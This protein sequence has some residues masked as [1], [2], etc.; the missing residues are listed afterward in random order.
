MKCRV[1]GNK[2]C[3][4]CGQRHD[5]VWCRAP[6]EQVIVRHP[7]WGYLVNHDYPAQWVDSPANAVVFDDRR[8]ARHRLLQGWAASIV[9]QMVYERVP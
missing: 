3:P 6:G 8:A 4:T 5:C 1:C 2:S 9:N 7:K